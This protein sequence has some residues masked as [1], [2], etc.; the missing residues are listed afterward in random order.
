MSILS[1]TALL[2]TARVIVVAAC[3]IPMGCTEQISSQVPTADRAVF[4]SDV[5][6]VLLEDCGFHACHG[7][8]ERFFQVF[9]P[10]H[11]RLALETRPLDLVTPAEL[12]HSYTRALSMLDSAEPEKSPLLLKP[13]AFTAGG[14][15]HE[16]TDSLGRNIYQSKNDTNYQLLWA[17][18]TGSSM[19]Q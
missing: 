9:G 5:F 4:E 3:A 19:P 15:G 14:S 2:R 8:S 6:P 18:A 11:G 10:G 13:L 17:W 7:S 16:G 1:Q 12:D